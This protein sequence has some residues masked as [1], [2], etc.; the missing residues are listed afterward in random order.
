MC[1]GNQ[2]NRK[3]KSNGKKRSNTEGKENAPLQIKGNGKKGWVIGE[4]GKG[5]RI[6]SDKR[7]GL[8]KR[9]K[10]ICS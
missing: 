6:W 2:Q 3:C 5:Q 10:E 1:R 7:Q 9:K 4:G 8:I